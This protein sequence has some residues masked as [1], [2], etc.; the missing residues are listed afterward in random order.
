[1]NAAQYTVPV[2]INGETGTGKEVVAQ[3]IHEMSPRRE[4]PFIP[5]NCGALP[6]ELIVNELFGHEK[7]AYTGAAKR[8]MGL[9]DQAQGGTL[10]LD[11]VDSL[12]LKAQVVLLRFL[13]DKQFRMLGGQR[14]HT[15]DVR[16]LCASNADFDEL[17][18]SGKFRKDLYYRLNVLHIH[19]PP[20][21]ERKNEIIPLAKEKMDLH[22]KEHG[23][24]VVQFTEEEIEQLVNYPWPG[25]IR[26]LENVILRFVIMGE[27]KLF[28]MAERSTLAIHNRNNHTS[29]TSSGSYGSAH[30]ST[31]VSAHSSASTDNGSIYYSVLDRRNNF[32]IA[33]DRRANAGIAHESSPLSSANLSSSASNTTNSPSNSPSNSAVNGTINGSSLG[34]AFGSSLGSSLGS[35]GNHINGSNFHSSFINGSDPNENAAESDFLTTTVM[36]HAATPQPEKDDADLTQLELEDR[37]EIDRANVEVDGLSEQAFVIAKAKVVENFEKRFLIELL[38]KSGGN[39]TLAARISGKERRAFGKLL[40]KYGVDREQYAEK[41]HVRKHPPHSN[42]QVAE[43]QATTNTSTSTITS[44]GQH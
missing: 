38:K 2:L 34:S 21:R 4:K 24:S 3:T 25:N 41:K 29:N 42:T 9:V 35:N 37:R 17:I 10:F 19:L 8:H 31:H 18:E 33:R 30:S 40:K 15:A 43:S 36:A 26:E 28:E 1:M 6:D 22:C 16:I 11:E 44:T 13:Q 32:R 7:G 5:V 14:S 27:L 20:L 39:V 12:S 23:L